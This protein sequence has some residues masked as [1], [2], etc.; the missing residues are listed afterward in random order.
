MLHLT[1]PRFERPSLNQVG[2][3]HEE[4]KA[5]EEKE[6]HNFGSALHE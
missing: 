3:H 6:P 4:E 2:P 1:D 5:E